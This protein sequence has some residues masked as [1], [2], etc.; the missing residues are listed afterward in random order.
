MTIYKS[1]LRKLSMIANGIIGALYSYESPERNR[2]DV[3]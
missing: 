1:I 3:L 2:Y